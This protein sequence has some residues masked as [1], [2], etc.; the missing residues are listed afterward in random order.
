LILYLDA[1]ALVKLVARENESEFVERLWRG[2]S[3]RSTANVAWVEV[4]SAI[5]RKRRLRQLSAAGARVA[6]ANWGRVWEAIMAVETS[7][8]VLEG[9]ARAT[10]RYG[11]S[12]LDALHL[13]SFLGVLEKAGREEVQFCGY[14]KKLTTAVARAVERRMRPLSE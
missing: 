1:S 8:P 5:S 13:S 9:A 14:D 2:A 4:H 11:L 3:I 12:A 10:D 6:R 7:A